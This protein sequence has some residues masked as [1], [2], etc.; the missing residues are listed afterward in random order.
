MPWEISF[1]SRPILAQAAAGVDR[2]E[3]RAVG[4]GDLRRDSGVSTVPGGT[5]SAS[6]GT[7]SVHSSRR[8]EPE[9]ARSV[10]WSHGAHALRFGGELLNVETG[11]ATS[12]HYWGQFNFHRRFTA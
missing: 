4:R 12:A 9:P 1:N 2:I 10:S 7:T 6:D 11:F 5:F 8:R 3:E